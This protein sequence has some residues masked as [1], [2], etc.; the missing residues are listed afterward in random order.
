MFSVSPLSNLVSTQ[1]FCSK[2]PT[3]PTC[4][5]CVFRT[6]KT[7]LNYYSSS[8]SSVSVWLITASLFVCL[9]LRIKSRLKSFCYYLYPSAISCYS[10]VGLTLEFWLRTP[11]SSVCIKGSKNNSLRT[12][13]IFFGRTILIISLLL[14]ISLKAFLEGK[15]TKLRPAYSV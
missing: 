11:F 5:F 1:T 8:E 13:T 10:K 15:I 7:I 3:S 14:E 4:S 6:G 9:M 12:Y 2:T